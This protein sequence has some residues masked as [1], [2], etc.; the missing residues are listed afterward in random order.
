M[1]LD[2]LYVAFLAKPFTFWI[3]MA[4]M[5]LLEEEGR[6]LRKNRL[7]IQRRDVL[8]AEDVCPGMFSFLLATLTP[9]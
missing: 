9:H 3:T 5:E 2:K 6:R 1:F 7:G 4:T 8:R